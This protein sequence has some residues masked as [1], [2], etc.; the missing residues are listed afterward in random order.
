[1]KITRN[2]IAYVL[3][4]S[5]IAGAFYKFVDHYG[6]QTG[7]RSGATMA[8]ATTLA[9]LLLWVTGWALLRYEQGRQHKI[10]LSLIY[11][12]IP[13]AVAAIGWGVAYVLSD[14]VQPI[15]LAWIAVIG[16]G[17]LLAHWF[18]ARNKSKGINSKK[19][20]L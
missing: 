18:I 12:V 6:N 11:H 15:D 7:D 20:F 16:G 4:S 10:N 3:I 13:V 5:T 19:A 9:V 14:Y 1:M 2:E 17:S 8:A